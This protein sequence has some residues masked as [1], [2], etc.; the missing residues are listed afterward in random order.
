MDA[1]GF[2]DLVREIV[3]EAQ[4]LKD[5]RTSETRA[6]VNYACIFAQSSREFA[7]LLRHA[8]NLG[9]PVQETATGPIYQI[10]PLDTS[11][12]PLQLLKIRTPD[13]THF[14]R[15][16]A[17]F[18]VSDYAAFKRDVLKKPGFTVISKREDFEMIELMDPAFRVR[19]YFSKPPMDEQLGLV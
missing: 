16:D 10:P 18:T 13:V 11:A 9:E 17:D 8:D 5:A 14:D 15:G 1:S 7:E 4:A 19:A 6:R 12:G 2:E 3:R